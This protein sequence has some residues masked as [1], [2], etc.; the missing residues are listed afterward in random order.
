MPSGFP[1]P[2]T[3]RNAETVWT[4]L[5]CGTGQTESSNS[6]FSMQG[7]ISIEQKKKISPG[8]DYRFLFTTPRQYSSGRDVGLWGQQV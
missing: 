7:A 3:L 6:F 2:R 8:Q 5:R 4:I 1:Q